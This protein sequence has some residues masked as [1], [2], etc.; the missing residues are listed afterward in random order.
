M[1]LLLLAAVPFVAFPFGAFAFAFCCFLLLFVVVFSIF[2]AFC[3]LLLL[4]LVCFAFQTGYAYL[5]VFVGI[6]C[7]VFFG[8]LCD[9]IIAMDA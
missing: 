6:I 9:Y 5:H 4:L 3:L 8:G 2:C 1:F 7:G